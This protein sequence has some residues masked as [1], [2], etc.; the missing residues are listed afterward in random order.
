MVRGN[1]ERLVRDKAWSTLHVGGGGHSHVPGA[2]LLS[3]V[4]HLGAMM[5]GEV[6][7]LIEDQAEVYGWVSLALCLSRLCQEQQFYAS[8]LRVLEIF[9]GH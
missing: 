1:H 5:P 7:E 2:C 4:A 9:T 6:D 3:Q 8:G